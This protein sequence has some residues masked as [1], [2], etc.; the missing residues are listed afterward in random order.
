MFRRLLI[1]DW[2]AIFT[3]IAFITALSVY[4]TIFYRTVRMRRSRAD[5]LAHLPFE[6]ET[7]ATPSSH[8]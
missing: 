3:I 5:E 4:A 6:D 8:E 7:T 1:E 2:T